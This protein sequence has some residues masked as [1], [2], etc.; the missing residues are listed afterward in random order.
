M[1]RLASILYS[2]IATSLAGVGVITVL[3]AGLISV[4]AIFGAA[5]IGALIAVPVSWLVARQIIQT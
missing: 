1:L 3:V 4:P 2:L 5:A